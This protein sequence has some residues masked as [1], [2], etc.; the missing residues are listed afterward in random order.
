MAI[1]R[2]LMKLLFL[3]AAFVLAVISDT[4]A[5][6]A[7]IGAGGVVVVIAGHV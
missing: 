3:R 2:K 4:I 5:A 7:I 1:K 6:N